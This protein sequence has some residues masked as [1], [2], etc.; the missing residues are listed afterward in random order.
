V[1]LYALH[2]GSLPDSVRCQ[3]GDRLP[4]LWMTAIG[5]WNLRKNLGRVESFP[6]DSVCTTQRQGIPPPSVQTLQQL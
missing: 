1:N 4:K 6:S 5:H 3:E 2:A